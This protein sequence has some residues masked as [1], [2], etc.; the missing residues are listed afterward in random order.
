MERSHHFEG[1]LILLLLAALGGIYLWQNQQPDIKSSVPVVSSNPA[2]GSLPNSQQLTFD[3]A[4]AA[5]R[6]KKPPT[7]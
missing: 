3:A 2:N 1:L 5:A 4:L 6:T 7:E